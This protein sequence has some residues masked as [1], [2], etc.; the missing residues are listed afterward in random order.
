M[1]PARLEHDALIIGRV[2]I[3]FYRTLRVPDDATSYALPPSLGVYPVHRVEDHADR[4]PASWR[5]HGGIFLPM[6]Q[7]EAMWLSFDAPHWTRRR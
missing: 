1:L 5:A 4:V 3:R 7:R 2:A 6:Y